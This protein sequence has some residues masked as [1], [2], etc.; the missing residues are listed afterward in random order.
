MFLQRS[1]ALALRRAASPRT[2]LP[3]AAKRAL[4]TTMVRRDT[5]KDIVGKIKTYNGIPHLP[6]RLHCPPKRPLMDT[7]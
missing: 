3:L 6:R 1:F 7:K 5:G 4:T 2:V